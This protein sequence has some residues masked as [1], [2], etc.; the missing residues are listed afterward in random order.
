M[1]HRKFNYGQ[2]ADAYAEAPGN[3]RSAKVRWLV[4][5]F[6]ASPGTVLRALN[7]GRT[8]SA[9]PTGGRTF[10]QRRL[11]LPVDH[12]ATHERRT[13]FP[14]MRREVGSQDL[15]KSGQF[16]AKL[17]HR[18]TKG[19]WKGFPIYSLTLEERATCPTS[20]RHWASC[21]GNNMQIAPRW[22]HGAKLEWRL[23]REIA[24]LELRHPDGFAVR[25][26]TLGDFYSVGYVHFWLEML[27]QHPALHVFGFTARI[28]SE[29]DDIA[30]ALALSVRQLWQRFAIRFSNAPVKRV[31]TISLESP[32]QKPDDAIICPAQWTPSGKKAE[33]CATCALC[34]TTTRRV[35]FLQH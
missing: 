21:Y 4:N 24:A 2:I 27:E 33:S 13:L 14:K 7:G 30:Y 29:T 18:I 9:S 22:K 10:G 34:W 3:S 17:G 12:P 6:E 15:L 19:A 16:S 25:L 11:V 35:A 28:D 1:R 5:R 31:S 20:C 23:K 8:T 26:H 32:L